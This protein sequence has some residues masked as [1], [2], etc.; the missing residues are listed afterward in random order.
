MFTVNRQA[1]TNVDDDEDDSTAPYR[2]REAFKSLWDAL[3]WKHVRKRVPVCFNRTLHN[4]YMLANLVYLS[5]TI[6]LLV[7]DFHPGFTATSSDISTSMELSNDAGSTLDQPVIINLHANRL[8]IALAGVNILVAFLYVWAWRDRSWFDVVLI[9][10]YLNHVQAALYLWSALWYPKQETIGDYYAIAV[11]R[12][13]LY[14]SCVELCTAVGWMIS[15]YMTYTRTFGRGFT[16]DD[17]DTMGYL[18][19]TTNTLLYFVYNIQMNIH[20]EQY[21]SNQLY[22][23]AD[24]LGFIGSIYYIFAALRDDKWLWFLPLAGQYD[25]A[26]GSVQVETKT[27]PKYGLSNVLITDVCKR[28]K[29]KNEQSNGKIDNNT[30]IFYL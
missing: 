3:R 1:I 6:A 27:L 20:P 14:A 12:I 21:G 26:A 28:R 23:Y 19:T 11:H 16:F 24:V 7:I 18:A 5:Y 17:P 15:W 30:V 22:I 9:P 29:E 2:E 10:E 4:R 8:Y 25:V 13:E